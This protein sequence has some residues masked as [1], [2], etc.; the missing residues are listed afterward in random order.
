MQFSAG[1]FSMNKE[2]L[3]YDQKATKVNLIKAMERSPY[4]TYG[5]HKV[6]NKALSEKEISLQAVYQWRNPNSSK[7]PSLA[8]IVA[9]SGILGVELTDIIAVKKEVNE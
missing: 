3:Q 7:V 1:G 6:L 4:T 8:N 2:Y 5:L 9:L